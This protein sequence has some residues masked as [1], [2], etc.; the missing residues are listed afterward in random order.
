MIYHTPQVA[1]QA[2]SD[3]LSQG[4]D[5]RCDETAGV[6]NNQKQNRV[7]CGEPG[8]ARVRPQITSQQDTR[9]A[10]RCNPQELDQRL[11]G[12]GRDLGTL[13]KRPDSLV[14]SR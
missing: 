13:F 4:I 8:L 10:Q 11:G 7:K 3:P 12:R 14:T 6:A 9:L 5:A 2:R 1:N